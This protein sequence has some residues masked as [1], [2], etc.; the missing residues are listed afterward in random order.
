MLPTLLIPVAALIM[1]AMSLAMIVAL[2]DVY[3]HDMSII[4]PNLL[5]IWLFIAPI[6][7]RPAMSPGLMQNLRDLD[8]LSLTITQ[9]RGVLYYGA[10]D[11]PDLLVRMIVVTSAFFLASLM[12]FR[13]FSVQ[14][15]RDV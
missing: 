15:A 13:R 4:L 1:L 2:I 10:I 11:R 3:N 8:P 9:F 7:Y 5:T 6:V 14:L 12:T